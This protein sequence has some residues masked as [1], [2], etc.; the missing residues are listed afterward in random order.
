MIPGEWV[1]Q[2]LCAQVGGDM[3]YPELGDPHKP[4]KRVCAKCDVIEECRE[5][6]LRTRQTD[7]VWGGLSPRERRKLWGGVA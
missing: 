7:G 3:W 2:G 5:Y 1:E 4:A 6:A